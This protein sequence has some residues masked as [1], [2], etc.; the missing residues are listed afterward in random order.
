MNNPDIQQGKNMKNILRPAKT[1]II[2][3]LL[4]SLCFIL[5][6]IFLPISGFGKVFSEFSFLRKISS[7]FISWLASFIIYYPLT[8]GIAYIIG[9]IRNS[10]YN[11]KEIILALVFIAIFN[12]FTLAFAV[13]NLIPKKA[14]A[15]G[16]AVENNI[17]PESV[18][19]LRINDFAAGSKMEEAG[20]GKGDIIMKFNE[21]ELKSIQDIFNQLEK[22]RPGD[23]VSLETDKGLKTVELIR[24]TNN[25]NAPA[26]GVVLEPSSCRND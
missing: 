12:P 10:L 20:I 16:N 9:S 8:F 18:C 25:P 6:V 21:A 17:Q 22:K 14:L 5:A 19:G 2:I 7:F 24:N 13:S 26:L 23:K 11:A 1:K 15:P 4:L 3:H